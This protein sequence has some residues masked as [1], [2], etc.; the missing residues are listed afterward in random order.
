MLNIVNKALE[1]DPDFEKAKEAKKLVK[2][3]HRIP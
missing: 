3:I 1:L 2:A